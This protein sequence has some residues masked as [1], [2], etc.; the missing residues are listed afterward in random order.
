[1]G[2]LG[3]MFSLLADCCDVSVRTVGSDPT[4]TSPAIS[5]LCAREALPSTVM[6]DWLGVPLVCPTDSCK[7]E[8]PL[9]ETRLSLSPLF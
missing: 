8:L 1:M 9:A 6:F 7:L 2:C 4:F 3:A 5:R